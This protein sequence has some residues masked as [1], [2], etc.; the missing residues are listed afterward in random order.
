MI[1]VNAYPL[2]VVCLCPHR[3]IM[4]SRCYQHSMCPVSV[5]RSFHV[6]VYL[7]PL[8]LRLAGSAAWSPAAVFGRAAARI[9]PRELL[10]NV[11]CHRAPH[12]PRN[13]TRNLPSAC[14]IVPLVWSSSCL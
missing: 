10:V 8:P 1:A 2:C 6:C 9:D 11:V 13:P 14:A 4:V 5:A 7:S 12:C 3:V